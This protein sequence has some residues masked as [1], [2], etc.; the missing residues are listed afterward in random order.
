MEWIPVAC[1]SKHS[2]QSKAPE[3]RQWHI[4]F[5]D[6]LAGKPKLSEWNNHNQCIKLVHTVCEIA[7]QAQSE[8]FDDHFGHE[9]E[10]T[11]IIC[12]LK[13]HVKVII[14]GIAIHGERDRVHCNTQYNENIEARIHANCIKETVNACRTVASIWSVHA[15]VQFLHAPTVKWIL[16]ILFRKWICLLCSFP[17]KFLLFSRLFWLTTRWN[18]ISVK[19]LWFFGL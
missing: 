9:Y 14:N 11:Y 15:I 8:Q 5:S 2:K 12:D 6:V 4:I 7:A 10:C 17:Q 18:S 16:Q 1:K 3:N 19:F 13:I